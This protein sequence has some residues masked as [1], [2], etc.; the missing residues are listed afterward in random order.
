MFIILATITTNIAG[1]LVPPGMVFSSLFAKHLS[2]KKAIILASFLALL[3]QPWSVLA[4]PDNYI[5]VVLGNLAAFLGP[6]AGIYMASY[7]FEH[8]TEVDFVDLYKVT[9]GRYY[10]C[11]G[12][13]VTAIVCLFS[14]TFFCLISQF[15]NVS[16]FI[17]DNSYVIGA[18]T[19]FISYLL[20]IKYYDKRCNAHNAIA[21]R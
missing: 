20:V 14:I 21:V 8:K 9:E 3:G 7:W 12:V 5:F 19:A 10:Y 13:N 6:M 16:R 15:F 17:F 1:N 11:K 18:F 2:Y 4:D